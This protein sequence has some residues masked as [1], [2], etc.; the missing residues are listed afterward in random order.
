MT[1]NDEDIQPLSKIIQSIKK[2][3]DEDEEKE[4]WRVN[5]GVDRYGN[6]DLIISREPNAW[7]IKNKMIDPMRALSFGKELY[8]KDLN[9]EINAEIQKKKFNPKEAFHQLFGLGVPISEEQFIAATGI[10]RIS[11]NEMDLIQTKIEEKYPNTEKNLR[12]K[13]KKIWEDFYGDR[14]Q[15]YL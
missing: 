12:M 7:Y 15:M 4:Q 8:I 2:K 9:T 14:E 1:N 3:Y 6:N 10:Q 11:K 5:G 13:L